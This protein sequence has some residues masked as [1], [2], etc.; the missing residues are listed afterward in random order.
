MRESRDGGCQCGAIR[1]RIGRTLGLAACHCADCQRQS[2]SAFGLSL[3]VPAADFELRSG[4]LAAFEWR[5]DS[6]RIKTCS[7]CPKCGTRIHHRTNDAVLSLKAG[8]LDDPSDLVPDAHYW[9][10]RKLAWVTLPE[11][12]T[13]IPDDG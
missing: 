9:V 6:G 13:A 10:K 5:C 7:F 2:G 12:A 11:G 8:T 3:A 1:Y 4:A